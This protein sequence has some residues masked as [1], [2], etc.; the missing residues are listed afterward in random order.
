MHCS[1]L[2]WD[3]IIDIRLSLLLVSDNDK[4]V[5]NEWEIQRRKKASVNQLY[6]YIYR[7][8]NIYKEEN[9]VCVIVRRYKHR[10]KWKILMRN[11]ALGLTT[12]RFV[13]TFLIRF[14]LFIFAYWIDSSLFARTDINDNSSCSRYEPLSFDLWFHL[15]LSSFFDSRH[16]KGRKRR[17]RRRR[18]KTRERERKRGERER[19]RIR[20]RERD[21]DFF[22]P[23]I[24]LSLLILFVCPPLV[25][26]SYDKNI[27]L[28]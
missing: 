20:E 14:D 15:L 5:K 25:N 7:S 12:M 16:K 3:M 1:T 9:D 17:R 19:E 11:V 8:W 13:V 2:S 4:W 23:L 6:V 22:V 27:L 10:W 21:D 26:T 28:F 18:R 24:F